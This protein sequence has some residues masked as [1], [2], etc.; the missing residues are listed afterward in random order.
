MRIH[1][2]SIGVIGA[3]KMGQAILQGLL[4]AGVK[5]NLIA[6]SEPDAA[7]RTLLRR[8]LKISAHRK[9]AQAAACDVVILAIKPQVMQSVL[10]EVVPAMVPGQLII[11]IAAGI[12][13]RA[14]EYYLPKNPVVRAM[15]NLPATIGLGITALAF[16]KC[17][18]AIHRQLAIK[19]FDSVGMTVVIPEKQFDAITAVSGSGPAYVFQLAQAWQIAAVNLGVSPK[20]AQALVM[21]TL[22]GSVSLLEASPLGAQALVK[23]VA[24]KGGTTEAALKVFVKRQFESMFKEAL[25][26]A[27]KRSKELSC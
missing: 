22:K 25:S 27:A 23:Q 14:L 8:R 26:A 15:P 21:Q 24:S 17:C 1:N 4:G 7:S 5:P 18:Q 19:L 20:S 3:G 10:S 16:G 9:N 12:K 6:A 2:K 11:S 13:I